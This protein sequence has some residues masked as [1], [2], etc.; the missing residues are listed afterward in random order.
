MILNWGRGAALIYAKEY[1]KAF[2]R[3]KLAL[4]AA[5]KLEKPKNEKPNVIFIMADDLGYNDI[6]YNSDHAFMPNIDFLANNG[7]IF[8]SFYT[9]PVCT[10]SR[11]Q[12]MTGDSKVK[13]R[14]FEFFQV[15]TRI[16]TVS[17]TEIS[18]ARSLQESPWTRKLYPN[19]SENAVTRPK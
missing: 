16:G 9:Q 7:I 2:R 1:A 19:T 14:H 4:K 11:A 12:F 3:R 17:S 10:P 8:D 15:A 13:D 5:T 6:G 18:S